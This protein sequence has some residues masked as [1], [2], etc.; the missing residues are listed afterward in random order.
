MPPNLSAQ[1]VCPTPKVWDFDEKSLHWLPV[2]R[3]P[4]EGL[5]KST[6][7]DIRSFFIKKSFLTVITYPNK[8]EIRRAQWG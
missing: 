4:M 8:N 6:Y 1:I 3:N 2:V 5:A 7:H